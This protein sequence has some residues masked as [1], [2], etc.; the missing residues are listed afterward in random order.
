MANSELSSTSTAT[1]HQPVSSAAWISTHLLTKPTVSGTPMRL[2]PPTTNAPMVH[3]MRRPSPA[4]FSSW[5][6]PMR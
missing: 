5:T 4:M 3:G 1:S 6:E 2:S